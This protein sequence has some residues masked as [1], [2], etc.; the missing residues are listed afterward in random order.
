[1]FLTLTSLGDSFPLVAP[2]GQLTGVLSLHMSPVLHTCDDVFTSLVRLW[3]PLY[4]THVISWLRV[5]NRRELILFF[6]ELCVVFLLGSKFFHTVLYT[7]Q[8]VSKQLHGNKWKKNSVNIVKFI[9]CE[10]NSISVVNQLCRRQ[11]CLW[12]KLSS[13]LNLTQSCFN[14]V[15]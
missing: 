5:Q 13:M 2:F 6:Y 12:A 1:M 9:N 15:Q 14:S 10:N 4:C 3:G 7:I 11:S 8:I